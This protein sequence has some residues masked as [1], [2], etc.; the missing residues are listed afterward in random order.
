MTNTP[1]LPKRPKRIAPK[2]A[3]KADVDAVGDRLTAAIANARH[4]QA[5][6]TVVAVLA[7]GV[8]QHLLTSSPA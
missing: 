6:W 2:A 1:K 3:S 8:V 4:T 7:L 5:I